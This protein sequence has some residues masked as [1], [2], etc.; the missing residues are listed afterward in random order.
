MTLQTVESADRRQ[1]SSRAPRLRLKPTAARVGFVDGAWWPRRDDLSAELPE[2]LA[3]L[4][5]WLGH[6]ER[7]RYRVAEWRP[8]PRKLHVGRNIVELDGSESQPTST[9][10]LLTSGFRQ[11]DLLV[12]AVHA[13]ASDAH[14]TMMRAAHPADETPVDRLL[15]IVPDARIS[16]DQAGIAEQRWE[17]VGG[18][19]RDQD[20]IGS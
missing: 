13:E 9:I 10:G 7:V 16:L 2:L 4:P 18:N 11:L 12:V 14:T 17:S 20:R 3:A 1:V 15:G 5:A 8:A 19:A 6:I